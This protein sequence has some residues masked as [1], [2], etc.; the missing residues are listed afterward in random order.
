M[1]RAN[2]NLNVFRDDILV[3]ETAVRLE[4]SNTGVE[5]DPMNRRTAHTHH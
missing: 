5:T 3:N 2:D 4:S 1:T